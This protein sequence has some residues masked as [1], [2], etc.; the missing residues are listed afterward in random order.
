MLQTITIYDQDGAEEGAA[1]LHRITDIKEAVRSQNRVNIFVDQKFFCSLDISQVVGLSIKVGRQL[2]DTELSELK[3]AS[4]FGK[5]YGRALEYVFSRP[6]STKEI[7]DYL[8]RKTYSRKIRVKNRQ[9]GEYQTKTKEGFDP[10]LVPLVLARLEQHG[11][12]DDQKFANFWLENHHARKGS[13]LKKLRQ[14]LQQKGLSSDV[15]EQAFAD[16]SRDELI[17][18]RKIIA[19]KAHRYSDQQKF[20]QYLLR[21]GFNYSDVMDELSSSSST[22]E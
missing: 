3:K 1:A 13:S 17:E 11:Y 19:K 12:L 10:S 5:L 16:S 22:D 18:L 6:H 15:I 7:R 4:D 2:D 21:Q 9:T 14:E 20:I 8:K